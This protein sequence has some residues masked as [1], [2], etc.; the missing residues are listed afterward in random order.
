M[1]IHRVV[2]IAGVLLL[3]LYINA[4]AQ[5]TQLQEEQKTPQTKIESFITEKGSLVVKDYYELG[6]VDNVDF[7]ALVAYYPGKE[8][9][10]VKGIQVGVESNNRSRTAFLDLEEVEELAR[11]LVFMDNLA[12]DWVKLKKLNYAE[13][14]YSTKDYFRVGFYRSATSKASFMKRMFG[15]T[16]SNPDPVLFISAGNLY[17][18]E[19]TM[20]IDH[21]S[22][23]QEI[24]KKGLTLLSQK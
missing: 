6:D 5:D 16:E 19:K 10:K 7:V 9:E 12:Q 8:N 11:V 3:A 20:D 21:I 17:R 1:G 24:V 22:E 23:L 18:A 15:R 2:F 13:S 4:F 14:I